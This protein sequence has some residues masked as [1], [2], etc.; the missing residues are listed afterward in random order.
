MKNPAFVCLSV[1]QACVL[2]IFEK[3]SVVRGRD[4]EYSPPRRF[5]RLAITDFDGT[6][7]SRIVLGGLFYNEAG[8]HFEGVSFHMNAGAPMK[9][10]KRLFLI[11]IFLVALCFL[12]SKADAKNQEAAYSVPVMLISEPCSYTF[13]FR[14]HDAPDQVGCV[15]P[16]ELHE[17]ANG[18][19]AFISVPVPKV[20]KKEPE[21]SLVGVPSFFL[22]T[23][24]A[25]SFTYADSAPV[26]YYEWT[27]SGVRNR[28]VNVRV[29]MRLSP[30][31]VQGDDYELDM[32]S[33]GIET[34]DQYQLIIDSENAKVRSRSSSKFEEACIAGFGR[35]QN[36]LL[37]LPEEWGGWQKKVGDELIQDIDVCNKFKQ[38]LIGENEDTGESIV[39]HLSND[40]YL[41]WIVG[42][43]MG[44]SSIIGVLSESASV[45]G[46]GFAHGSPAFRIQ[47]FTQASVEARVIWDRHDELRVTKE[48]MKDC[49]WDYYEDYEEIEWERWPDPI[50]CKTIY[51]ITKDWNPLCKPSMRTCGEKYDLENSDFWWKPVADGQYIILA[52]TVLVPDGD[53]YRYNDQYDFVV[54]QA[55]PL[56]VVP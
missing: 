5:A 3:G 38:D 29:Q 55:Q 24:D 37:L 45:S 53:G 56:L 12:F 46:S 16:E 1:G 23:W 50:F 31:A 48:E 40:R 42:N 17:L 13:E 39:P 15:G 43:V 44:N 54:I 33:V 27:E 26:Q 30:A 4:T 20:V 18:N 2:A 28:L 19:V 34:G 36:S 51:K 35:S 25:D 10:L 11:L 32:G 21:L 47:F 9:V 22:V 7:T 41:H 52:N 49:S 6:P 8:T 14:T